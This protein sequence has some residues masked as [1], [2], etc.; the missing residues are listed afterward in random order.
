[1][2]AHLVRDHVQVYSF[3][4]RGHR[5]THK[6]KLTVTIMRVE[7]NALIP[8]L[9]MGT[10]QENPFS[11]EFRH[12]S[13]RPISFN[14]STESFFLLRLR[15]MLDILLDILVETLD[16][17]VEPRASEAGSEMKYDL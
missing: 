10:F 12:R 5:S 8:R 11:F 7:L 9:I 4:V 13:K 16:V 14:S 2:R 3:C 1:M 15:P 6:H 17:L